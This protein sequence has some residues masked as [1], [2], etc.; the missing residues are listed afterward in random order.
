[1]KGCGLYDCK[2]HDLGPLKKN[3]KQNESKRSH[4]LL[5]SG[6]RHVFCQIRRYPRIDCRT[7]NSQK[8]PQRTRRRMV[9]LPSQESSRERRQ[10]GIRSP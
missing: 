9:T 2:N 10:W 6:E 5:T 8:K 4:K 7:S 3:Q 1:M